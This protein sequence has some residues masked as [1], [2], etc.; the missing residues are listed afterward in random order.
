MRILVAE[1]DPV[2]R[3]VLG[4]MLERLGHA[5][6]STADGDEAWH[7]F[8]AEEPE[9]VITDWMMPELDG[10]ELCRR[11]RAH[12]RERY[13]YVLMLTALSGR[14]HYLDGMEAGADDFVTKPLDRLELQAR[15]RVA[16]RLLGL[17]REVHQLQ[18]LLPICSYCKRIRDEEERW[19]QVEDYVA[20]RTA[21]QFTHGVCPA[22]Y[23]ARLRPQLE[24]VRPLTS[25][26]AP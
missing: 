24:V 13:T 3:R 8:L 15:L 12:G 17:Q 1:D 16:E 22:C 26:E 7:R 4:A 2:S 5:V 14:A 11:I 9:V 25:E 21:A 18:G 20:R 23:D 6:S 19:S 10:L